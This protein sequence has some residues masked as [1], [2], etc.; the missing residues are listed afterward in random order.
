MP[1]LTELAGLAVLDGA[2]T[3][4]DCGALLRNPMPVSAES[5]ATIP[6]LPD[7]RARAGEPRVILEQNLATSFAQ[8]SRADFPLA[9][10]GTIRFANLALC[11]LTVEALR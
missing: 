11:G 9:A 3:L 4:A 7:I 2:I 6:H 5:T 10:D 1:N 8:E